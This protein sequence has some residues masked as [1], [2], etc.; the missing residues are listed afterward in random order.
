[1]GNYKLLD[2]D[3]QFA[4]KIGFTSDK[5]FKDTSHLQKDDENVCILTIQ[6]VNLNESISG[7][8]G[9][10][11]FKELCNNILRLGY[12][13]K[14]TDPI[15]R[16]REIII[17]EKY[18]L[19]HEKS[20]NFLF[21][22]SQ[23]LTGEE[24]VEVWTKK[25]KGVKVMK[26][27]QYWYGRYFLTESQNEKDIKPKMLWLGPLTE[28]EFKEGDNY[29]NFYEFRHNMKDYIEKPIIKKSDTLIL[30]LIAI[31][32]ITGFLIGFFCR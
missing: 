18:I 10:G 26:E 12:N 30:L 2:I 21:P 4:K 16:M 19:T 3:S 23:Y 11:Y 8:K 32:L 22:Y 17:K 13:I 24:D 15:L 27:K 14:I 20:K 1:M 25:S 31:S 29:N 28:K 5:F 6:T 7:S 9:T